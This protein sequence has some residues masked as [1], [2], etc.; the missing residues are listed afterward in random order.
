MKWLTE[1]HIEYRF[2]DFRKDG[3]DITLIQNWLHSL[4]W[5]ILLNK[6]STTW[7]QLDDSIK[8]SLSQ[9]TVAEIL[10]THPTLIKRPVLENG[11]HITVGFKVEHYQQL[12]S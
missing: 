1:H 5:E 4:D 12:F 11:Q 2:H 9:E 10:A 3:A 7:K 6:R 8:Q